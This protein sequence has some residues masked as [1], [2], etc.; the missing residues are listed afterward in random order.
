[1][2]KTPIFLLLLV[3]ILISCKKD[4][5]NVVQENIRIEKKLP[6]TE[7]L[8]TISK[9]KKAVS[10]KDN[11]VRHQLLYN[12]IDHSIY[13]YW[14]GTPWDFNGTTRIPQQGSIACGYFVTNTLTDLGFQMERINLAQSP[15][16]KMIKELCVDI[17][18][19]SKFNDLENYLKTQPNN[20]VFIIGLDFH[21][22]YVLKNNKD[23]Y[24]LHSNYMNR[25][26]VVKENIR[27]SVALKSSKSFMIGSLTKNRELIEKWI[28]S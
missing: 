19:F 27:K 1:M 18:H 7:F 2:S 24:F 14:K 3:F 9:K 26:G 12:L 20:S 23:F 10:D 16:S 6:Y 17:R 21:T 25:K 22:G 28:D 13:E 4:N 5:T 8:K 15:S 11:F